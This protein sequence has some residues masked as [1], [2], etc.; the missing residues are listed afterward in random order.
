MRQ[1]QAIEMLTIA[2]INAIKARARKAR[3]DTAAHGIKAVFSWMSRKNQK[4]ADKTPADLACA[5]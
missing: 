3:S 2:Q 1:E 5:C 4:Q